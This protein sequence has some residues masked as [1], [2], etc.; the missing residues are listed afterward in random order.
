MKRLLGLFVRVKMAFST[1]PDDRIPFYNRVYIAA[2]VLDPNLKMAWIDVDVH[3]TATDSLENDEE[4][5]E[6][7]SKLKQEVQG[8]FSFIELLNLKI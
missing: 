8:T 2:T 5:L 7:K 6:E 1:D 3:I 4:D